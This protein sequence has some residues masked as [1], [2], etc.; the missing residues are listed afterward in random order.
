ML[1]IAAGEVG[2][3]EVQLT[4]NRF[5][6]EKCFCMNRAWN[7]S[8][9]GAIRFFIENGLTFKVCRANIKSSGSL[10]VQF[11]TIE[12]MHNEKKNEKKIQKMIFSGY[13]FR[14]GTPVL[15]RFSGRNLY[16]WCEHSIQFRRRCDSAGERSGWNSPPSPGS[17]LEK[18][19]GNICAIIF[20][21]E[22]GPLCMGAG[23]NG[24]RLSGITAGRNRRT[25]AG[26]GFRLPPESGGRCDGLR[27]GPRS[28]RV[29]PR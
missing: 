15:L 13:S 14:N 4:G 20:G 17:N 7:M 3:P 11:F 18:S 22:P 5:F 19:H 12:K 23:G 6:R 2:I 24:S 28:S 9:E 29:C 1:E 27:A 21:M 16:I 26:G 8:V 10:S 25:P